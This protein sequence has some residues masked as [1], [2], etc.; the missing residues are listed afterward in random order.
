MPGIKNLLASWNE[1]NRKDKRSDFVER[2]WHYDVI[3]SMSEQEFTEEYI[4]W[5]KRKEIRP[6]PGKSQ[7]YIHPG[8]GKY[9]H[10]TFRNLIGQNAGD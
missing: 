2:F 7:S 4:L 8:S 9:S 6:K 5:A 1:T 3:T 10:I